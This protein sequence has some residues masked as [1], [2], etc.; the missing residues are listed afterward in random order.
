V[1]QNAF[2]FPLVAGLILALLGWARSREAGSRVAW[3]A[4]LAW[5]LAYGLAYYAL[6]D[7]LPPWP[8]KEATH[9]LFYAMLLSIPVAASQ[10]R[11]GSVPHFVLGSALIGG[12]V[13]LASEPLRQYEWEGAHAWQVPAG[14][15]GVAALALWGNSDLVRVRRTGVQVPGAFALTLGAT[16]FALG[17]S[18]GGSANLAGGIAA[19]GGLWCVLA[20]VRSGKA[21]TYG[22]SLPFTL[23]LTGLLLLGVG[24]AKTPLSSAILLALAPQAIRIGW[25]VERRALG[26]L[27]SVLACAAVCAI[28][29]YLSLAPPEPTWN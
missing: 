3:A 24:Y 29:A 13:W 2:L 21:V 7:G 17:Q 16:A 15:I 4:A 22:A 19:L 20:L 11:A 23:A 8:P 26:F 10:G 14:I 12:F 6:K 25:P 1:V 28:A 18:T 5:G 9:W 27:L